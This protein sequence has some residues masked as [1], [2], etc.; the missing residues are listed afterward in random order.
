M[1]RNTK[2]FY[3][4]EAAIFLPL[5]I[6]AVLS[7]GYFMRVSGAWENCIYGALD[8]SRQA[9]L[10]SYDG[11]HQLSVGKKIKERLESDKK[12][13]DNT[14]VSCLMV[15]YSD[16]YSNHITSYRLEASLKLELPAG[17]SREFDFSAD[18]KFRGFRGRDRLGEP[19]GSEGLEKSEPEDPVR[20]FPYAG[21]KYHGE[22]C[23]YVRAAVVRKVLSANIRK[24]CKSCSVCGSGNMKTGDVVFC[25]E[26][27]GTAYH[28]GTCRMVD[29]HTAVIDRSEAE[30][31]GYGVCSKCGGR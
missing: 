8:E 17:F 28:R 21:E 31:K 11:V 29:R 22:N 2:G 9:A 3:T 19:L 14:E 1:K 20:I 26:G 23:T 12:N 4:L 6:L 24:S 30:Q 16:G 5:V 25:F 15:D 7:V 10:R 27:S 18:I 13:P